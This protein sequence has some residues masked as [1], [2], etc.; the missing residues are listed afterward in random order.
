MSDR[1]RIELRNIENGWIARCELN[2]V[3][4]EVYGAS[5]DAAYDNA[6]V[7]LMTIKQAQTKQGRGDE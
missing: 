4:V 1:V 5:R 6:E 3:A 2:G 7:A